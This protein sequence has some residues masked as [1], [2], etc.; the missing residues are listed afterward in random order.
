[1][2]ICAKCK[3]EKAPLYISHDGI[4]DTCYN[5]K[6][7]KH[8][9]RVSL[10]VCVILILGGAFIWHMPSTPVQEYVTVKKGEVV[11]VEYILSVF[12]KK[13]AIHFVDGTII[14]M[15]SHI[16]MPSKNIIIK[17]PKGNEDHYYWRIEKGEHNAKHNV[18]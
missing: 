14:M 18:N 6:A 4:C 5:E 16:E 17:K 12:D 3:K 2:R 10:C 9:S 8:N 1:M 7:D 11:K 13:T 15:P